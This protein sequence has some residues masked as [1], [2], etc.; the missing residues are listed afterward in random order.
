MKFNF[1]EE[2][3]CV[4]EE[5]NINWDDVVSVFIHDKT[6]F[7]I[8]DF[9]KAANF[10]YDVREETVGVDLVILSKHWWLSRETIGW[11]FHSMPQ[12]DNLAYSECSETVLRA[13]Y[14]NLS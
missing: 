2:I 6:K 9:K 1:L 8:Q 10:L 11:I 12:C 13:G 7:S 4:F 14:A 3:E 5:Y